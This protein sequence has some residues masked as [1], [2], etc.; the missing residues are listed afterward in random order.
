MQHIIGYP[1]RNVANF[2]ANSLQKI[3]CYLQLNTE[4]LMSSSIEKNNSNHGQ[5]KI[6]EI[7]QVLGANIYI[8]PIGGQELYDRT[9]FWE[10]SIQLYFINSMFTPY[11]Q[12]KNEFVAGLSMLDILMFNSKEVINEMLD[13]YKL[14]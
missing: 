11:K 9:Y 12:F 6:M 1:D 14:I 10:K 4:F 2:V 8:N 7:C 5:I 13:N 3:S